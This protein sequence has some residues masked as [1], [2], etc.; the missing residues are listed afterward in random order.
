MPFVLLAKMYILD[1]AFVPRF[2]G[3]GLNWEI[4]HQV[5]L[6]LLNQGLLG[7]SSSIHKYL[8]QN[9]QD[10]LSRY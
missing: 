8:L 9:P 2:L 5:A 1:I 6:M 4:P 3:K 7:I 10:A